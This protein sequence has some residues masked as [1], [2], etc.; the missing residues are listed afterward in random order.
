MHLC[1]A[2]SARTFVKPFFLRNNDQLHGELHAYWRSTGQAS[3]ERT[4][5]QRQVF[6]LSG[7]TAEG[8]PGGEP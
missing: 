7:R 3:S 1:L 2:S 4:G 5:T 8:V 6:P